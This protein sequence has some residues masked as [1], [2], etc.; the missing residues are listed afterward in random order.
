YGLELHLLTMLRDIEE[1]KPRVVILDPISTLVSSGGHEDVKIMLL[2]L[3]DVLKQKQITTI[4]T[5]LTTRSLL[6]ATDLNVSSFV[7][8]WILLRDVESNG[9]RNRLLHVLKSRGMPHSNQVREMIISGEGIRLQPVYLGSDGMAIGSA[10]VA[11][12]ASNK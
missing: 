10:R 8:T 9:E 7:D 4:L 3:I 6:E 1:F 11:Q 12:E 2:R 5:C